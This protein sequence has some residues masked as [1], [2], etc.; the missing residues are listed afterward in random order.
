MKKIAQLENRGLA[1]IKTLR[2]NKL[3]MGFPFMIN[4]NSLKSNQFYY[5]Y[6]DGK[7]RLMI[8]CK[9]KSDFVVLQELGKKASS[10]VRN[11]YLHI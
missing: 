2:K 1:A 11:K 10:V 3:E 5:E 8:Y 9:E 6:P 7:I 4:S